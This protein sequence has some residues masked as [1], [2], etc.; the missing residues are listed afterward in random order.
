MKKLFL[1]AF[2]AVLGFVNAAAQKEASI[3][4]EKTTLDFGTV[5]PSQEVVNGTFVFT[6]VGKSPLVVNQVLPTCGCT[7]ATFTREPVAPGQKGKIEVT[8]NTRKG[9]S[10]GEKFKK[11]INV[12]TNGVPE[13]TRLVICGK[14]EA[15]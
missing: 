1:V 5:S 2:M 9:G 13:L 8:Y 7:V 10:P 6:N 3:E 15:E 4:F 11:I 14:L 12:R